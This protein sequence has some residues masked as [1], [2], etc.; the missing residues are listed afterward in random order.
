MKRRRAKCR[1]PGPGGFLGGA[2][3]TVPGAGPIGPAIVTQRPRPGAAA[4]PSLE[5]VRVEVGMAAGVLGEVVAP[6]E[7]LFA[8]GAGELLLARVSAEVPGQLIGTGKLLVAVF[9]AA[10]ERPLACRTQRK[11]KR[12]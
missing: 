12:S 5:H 6:H 3:G 1:G 7:A 8:E 10:F 4:T 2:A 9:P 11:E